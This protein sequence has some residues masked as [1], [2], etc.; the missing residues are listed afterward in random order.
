MDWPLPGLS[1]SRQRTL[2]MLPLFCFSIIAVVG[3]G[4]KNPL[5]PA[6]I[7]GGVSYKGKTV[8]GGSVQ[9]VTL[10]GTPYSSSI[11]VD[12]TYA[13]AD[14][15]IGEMAIVV[16]TESINPAAKGTTGKD[17][18]RR[19]A[20]MGERKG[21]NAGGGGGASALQPQYVKIP[22]KYSKAKTSPL[23]YTVKNGRQVYSIELE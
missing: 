15:P 20:M 2:V 8:T 23:T 16:E 3:C 10:G 22:E 4:A 1:M 9:F 17:A 18:D 21:P 6:S 19:N 14:L 13:V 7:S 12:G 11:S 5:A